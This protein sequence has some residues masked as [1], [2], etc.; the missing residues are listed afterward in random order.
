ML[1]YSFLPEVAT[2]LTVYGIE[3]CFKEAD[4]RVWCLTVATALTVYGIETMRVFYPSVFY[5]FSCNST[6]RLRY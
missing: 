2:A 5:L 6:Y 3:T 4:G 1:V